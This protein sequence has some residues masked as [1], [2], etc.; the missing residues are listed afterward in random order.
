[1]YFFVHN[2]KIFPAA[3]WPPDLDYFLLSRKL[4][5]LKSNSV[6]GPCIFNAKALPLGMGA[7]GTVFRLHFLGSVEVDEEGGR[8]RRKKLKK[9]MV[10]VAV[11]KIK[12]CANIS[13]KVCRF[14]KMPTIKNPLMQWRTCS[15]CSKV[16]QFNLKK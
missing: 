1:M 4:Q 15:V 10:E 12:V 2:V 5:I 6:E 16:Y 13:V 14:E 8:K 7:T 9:N 11:T 3:F